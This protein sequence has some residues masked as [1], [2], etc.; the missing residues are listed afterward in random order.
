MS[1]LYSSVCTVEL[2]TSAWLCPYHTLEPGE[3][4]WT[5]SQWGRGSHLFHHGQRVHTFH[6]ELSVRASTCILSLFN[7]VS[8]IH[9]CRHPFQYQAC[10]DLLQILRKRI[11]HFNDIFLLV[12]ILRTVFKIGARGSLVVK[13]LCYKLKGCGFKTRWGEW[14]FSI[15]LILLATLGPGVHSTSNRNKYQKQKNNI[16]VS[17]AQPVRRADNL[18][19]ICELIV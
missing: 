6:V 8:P 18:T 12:D 11:F 15:Y 4:P 3:G 5:T 2:R 10:W 16:S 13:A 14:I 19:A 9:Q 17:R 7:Y 1:L